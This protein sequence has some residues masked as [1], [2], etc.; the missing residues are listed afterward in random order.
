[1]VEKIERIE[2]TL[3]FLN[4]LVG[5]RRWEIMK[6]DNEIFLVS[7]VWHQR[8]PYMEPIEATCNE[9]G[10][11]KHPDFNADC[12]IHAYKSGHDTSLDV[13]VNTFYG[14]VYLWGKM[15]EHENGYRSEFAYP[16]DFRL[17]KCCVCDN[18]IKHAFWLDVTNRLDITSRTCLSQFNNLKL[19][20]T[21]CINHHPIW[22]CPSSSN[23]VELENIIKELKALYLLK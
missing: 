3:T 13:S 19:L 21:F 20:I 17:E 9:S 12:G 7:I 8:W 5:E 1:M 15:I 10:H 11:S 23:I 22:D 4:C 18:D 14:S 16:K 2:T 6:K